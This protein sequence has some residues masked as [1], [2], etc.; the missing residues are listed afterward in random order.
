VSA[1]GP[2]KRAE[3]LRQELAEHNRRYYIF[4]I[5]VF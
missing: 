4:D 1:A 2:E 3:E 5:F